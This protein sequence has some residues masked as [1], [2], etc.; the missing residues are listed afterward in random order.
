MTTKPALTAPRMLK[1]GTLALPIHEAHPLLIFGYRAALVERM[2]TYFIA[3][4]LAGELG[5]FE[6]RHPGEGRL[7]YGQRVYDGLSK[8]VEGYQLAVACDELLADYIKLYV[9]LVT[10][11][12]GKAA[13]D[14]S[15]PLP[16]ESSG[17]GSSA[18]DG[19][20]TPP[21]SG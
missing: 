8:T 13:E 3:C 20:D 16:V 6:P 12:Q 19:G 4:A 1:V 9:P 15:K 11:E 7:E 5:A 21:P 17:G 10:T 2:D 14:F 18:L